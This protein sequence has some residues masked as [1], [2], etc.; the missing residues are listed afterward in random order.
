MTATNTIWQQT[1][2]KEPT[3]MRYRETCYLPCRDTTITSQKESSRQ[4]RHKGTEDSC[5]PWDMPS[6]RTLSSKHI[7]MNRFIPLSQ[8]Q[9]QSSQAPRAVCFLSVQSISTLY[10]HSFLTSDLPSSNPSLHTS[11]VF[12]FSTHR[13]YKKTN[14]EPPQTPHYPQNHEQSS[15][16]RT[17]QDHAYTPAY[18]A[19]FVFF[20][21]K[22][23]TKRASWCIQGYPR[24]P[25]RSG[26][27]LGPTEGD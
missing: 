12:S 25:I 16:V 24:K 6:S 17:T 10:S 14:T 13:I 19:D 5:M 20:L 27:W 9:S 1:L 4:R 21:K 11:I 23:K 22:N 3:N 2:L 8:S 18:T 7:V 26:I 15:D